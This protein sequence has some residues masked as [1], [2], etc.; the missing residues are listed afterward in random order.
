MKVVMKINCYCI[1]DGFS[2]S[3]FF[4][5]LDS[6]FTSNKIIYSF[7]SFLILLFKRSLKSIKILSFKIKVMHGSMTFVWT[8]KSLSH[9]LL[10]LRSIPRIRI[11]QHL[12]IRFRISRF[13]YLSVVLRTSSTKMLHHS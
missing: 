12:I 11:L 8:I 9:F 3:I 5:S 10:S 4:I 13:T 2:S 7:S 1:R 6:R